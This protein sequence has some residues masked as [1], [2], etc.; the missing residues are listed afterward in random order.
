MKITKVKYYD[1]D[2]SNCSNFLCKCSIVF[3]DCVILHDIKI[4]KG[5]KGKYIT[6]PEKLG[7]KNTVKEDVFHPV[8]QS[9]FEYM[10]ESILKGYELYLKEGCKVYIPRR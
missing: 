5:K 3:D 1:I 4:L 2:M 8:N 9:Y 7:N 6:M 10:K